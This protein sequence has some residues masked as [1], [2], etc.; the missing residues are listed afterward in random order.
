[1]KKLLIF[2]LGLMFSYGANAACPDITGKWV[3]SFDSVYLGDTYA[4]VYTLNITASKISA[5]GYESLY[6]DQYYFKSS[7]GY[8]VN[9]SCKFTFQAAGTDAIWTGFIVSPDELVFI[10]S[11]SVAEISFKATAQRVSAGS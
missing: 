11:N 2:A 1:M 7:G 4:G 5:S 9:S 10:G 6:G 3:T 8:T